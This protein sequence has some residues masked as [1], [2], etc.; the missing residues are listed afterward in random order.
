MYVGQNQGSFWIML[1]TV[2]RGILLRN[3]K[4]AVIIAVHNMIF[5]VYGNGEDT[6]KV[7]ISLSVFGVT[8]VRRGLRRPV[9]A[10]LIPRVT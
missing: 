4:N 3:P 8:G 6:K 7:R 5:S 9:P 2:G 1:V 10:R